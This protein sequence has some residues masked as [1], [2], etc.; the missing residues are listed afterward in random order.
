MPF[1]HRKEYPESAL[2]S[3]YSGFG[4]TF[5]NDPGFFGIPFLGI[6][7]LTNPGLQLEV[8][9]K[10][11][12]LVFGVTYLYTKRSI[13]A[14]LVGILLTDVCWLICQTLVDFL[15]NT[16]FILLAGHLG[17]SPMPLSDPTWRSFDQYTAFIVTGLIPL[18]FSISDVLRENANTLA[19]WWRTAK[20]RLGRFIPGARF[21]PTL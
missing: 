12:C 9:A 1:G 17:G 20:E 4:S 18:V 8:S 16:V 7:I 19:G 21:I 11:V 15:M 3:I 6:G 13:G 2:A 10:T 5:R 14:A